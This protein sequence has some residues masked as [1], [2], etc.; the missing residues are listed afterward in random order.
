MLGV[1]QKGLQPAVPTSSGVALQRPPSPLRMTPLESLDTKDVPPGSL[2]TSSSR[3][4]AQVGTLTN[5]LSVPAQ[6]LRQAP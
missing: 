5:A 2:W 1:Q 4:T 6:G 3:G